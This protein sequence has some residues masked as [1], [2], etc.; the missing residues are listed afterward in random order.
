[1]HEFV[2]A[3]SS[4]GP[5][6]VK[7]QIKKWGRKSRDTI[8]K[9]NLIPADCPALFLCQRY[10]TSLQYRLYSLFSGLVGLYFA[11]QIKHSFHTLLIAFSLLAHACCRW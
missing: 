1:M 7:E 11:L 2:V 9:K 5:G 4:R 8:K 6:R 10:R 3:C